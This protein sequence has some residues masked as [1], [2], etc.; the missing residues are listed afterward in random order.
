MLA[1]R[2]LDETVYTPEALAL[3]DRL[4]APV[5]VIDF[6]GDNPRQW[7]ANLACLPL[8]AAASRA[9]LSDRST[10]TTPSEASRTRIE[11]LRRR[12]VA[13]EAVDER[14]SFYPEGG[15]PFTADCHQTG[16]WIAERA[17]A[18]AR[19]AMFV[20]ARVLGP[21]DVDPEARRGVE[22][23]RY[24]GELVSLYAESGAALMRNPAALRALGDPG[25]GD[26]LAAGLADP[27]QAAAVRAALVDATSVRL[28]LRMRTAGGE[29]WYDTELRRSIDPVTGAPALLV[30]QRDISERRADQARLAA[31]ADALRRLAAPVVRVGPGLLAVPL[32]GDLDA[33]RV[34]VALAAVGQRVGA[35]AVRRVV[36]DLT[37]V[38]AFDAVGAAGL[39]RIVRVL[40]LQGVDAALSGIRPDLA[41][42]LV[43]VGADLGGVACHASLA[44][45]LAAPH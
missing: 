39:L 8:F 41:R 12:L 7:W 45:A 5:W 28:D 15:E 16:I 18:D 2:V 14:W 42:T 3:F 27:D 37:G 1:V 29:R 24:L 19:L 43:E 26:R 4:K 13:G 6:A 33:D 34:E 10:G 36:L 35:E 9:A 20:E 21:G 30:T 17:G 40:R 22:A 44:D 23:L 25:D 38:A 31:Q 32:I 11:A